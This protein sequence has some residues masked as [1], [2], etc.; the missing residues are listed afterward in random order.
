MYL[1]NQIKYNFEILV[2]PGIGRRC[3]H[4]LEYSNLTSTRGIECD[5]S[6]LVRQRLYRSQ[7]FDMEYEKFLIDVQPD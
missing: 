5:T 4:M 2:S 7:W 6:L 3:Q 1:K